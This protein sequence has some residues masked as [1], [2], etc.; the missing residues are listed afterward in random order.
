ML[1]RPG[2]GSMAGRDRLPSGLTGRTHRAL[3]APGEQLIGG[4]RLCRSATAET[5]TAGSR[6]STTIR[7]FSLTDQLRRRAEPSITVTSWKTGVFVSVLWPTSLTP[8]SRM[9]KTYSAL[10][11]DQLQCGSVSTLA[12][13]TRRARECRERVILSCL[14]IPN[15][16]GKPGGTQDVDWA[17]TDIEV[18]TAG[19]GGTFPV[20]PTGPEP[21]KIAISRHSPNLSVRLTSFAPLLARCRITCHDL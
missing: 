10:L 1:S 3:P 5:L 14:D 11:R 2:R 15:I 20:A 17:K 7:A 9:R 16:T 13:L 4:L 21:D 12:A 6:L 19:L 8:A 18:A